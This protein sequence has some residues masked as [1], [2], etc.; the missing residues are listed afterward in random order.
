MEKNNIYL[1]L[2]KPEAKNLVCIYIFFVL[3]KNCFI[4]VQ[5]SPSTLCLVMCSMLTVEGCDGRK[6]GRI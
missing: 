5:P 3:F 1:S 4:G 2:Y 6:E